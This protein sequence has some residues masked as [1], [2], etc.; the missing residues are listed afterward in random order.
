MSEASNVSTA[1]EPVCCETCGWF[2]LNDGDF[3]LDGERCLYRGCAGTL[4]SASVV[5]RPAEVRRC[6][7]ALK[8]DS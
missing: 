8:G 3:D 4:Q 7:A 1:R 2:L 6:V 5:L